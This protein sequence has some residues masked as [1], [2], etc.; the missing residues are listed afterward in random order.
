MIGRRTVISGASIGLASSASKL[1]TVDD[2]LRAAD[3]AMY[4]AKSQS[5]GVCVFQ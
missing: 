5:L 1:A 3:T 4:R 2:Y